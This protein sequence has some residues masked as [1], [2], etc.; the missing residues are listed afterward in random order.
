MASSKTAIANMALSNIGI[1]TYI[2]DIDT[3]RS[4]EANVIRLYYDQARDSVLEAYDWGFARKSR[5]LTLTAEEFTNWEYAYSYP[6]DCV[7]ARRIEYEGLR[8]P[9]A[10]QRIP[11]EVRVNN[12]GT[13]RYIVTDQVDA[14]LV[15]T[16][17]LTDPNM[18]SPSFVNALST[19]LSSLIAMP[20]SVSTS[21]T[22]K[23]TARA[24]QV[25]DGAVASDERESQEDHPADCE[26]IAARN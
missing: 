3:E 15:Y 16:M 24:A 22:D 17:R 6:S 2:A 5:V 25:L 18:F 23:A 8:N 10:D 4:K 12:D 19:V 1:S 14:E 26:F 11:F 9:R 7:K 20:L 21:I 13:Q